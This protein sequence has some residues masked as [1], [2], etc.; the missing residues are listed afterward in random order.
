MGI[1]SSPE[2]QEDKRRMVETEWSYKARYTLNPT[3]K[4]DHMLVDGRGTITLAHLVNAEHKGRRGQEKQN[5]KKNAGSGKGES[6]LV[7][8]VA[9]ETI[10]RG[11]QLITVYVGTHMRGGGFRDPPEGT[12]IRGAGDWVR[13]GMVWREEESGDE[14]G[15]EPERSG[16]NAWPPMGETRVAVMEHEVARRGS[17]R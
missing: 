17:R 2:V 15:R 7:T 1:E 4:Q 3:G 13:N 12:R 14:I 10:A 16:V 11:E 6:G 9:M 8:Y 5:I